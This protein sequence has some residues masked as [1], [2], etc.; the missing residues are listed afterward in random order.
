MKDIERPTGMSDEDWAVAEPLAKVLHPCIDSNQAETTRIVRRWSALTIA[1]LCVAAVTIGGAVWNSSSSV[2]VWVSGQNQNTKDL[3]V[4]MREIA[5][6][7]KRL[8]SFESTQAA[9]AQELSDIDLAITGST[10]AQ[11]A[12]K[13]RGG[14]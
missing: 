3:I 6:Q 10:A 5:D 7:D 4:A 8:T 2:A 9:Q 11:R 14:K 12:A 1:S 13:A